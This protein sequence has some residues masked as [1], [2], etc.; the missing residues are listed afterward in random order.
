MFLFEEKSIES[1]KRQEKRQ[2]GRK[3][4]KIGKLNLNPSKT[5]GETQNKKKLKILKNLPVFEGGV[6]CSVTLLDVTSLTDRPGRPG[7]SGLRPF[8][9]ADCEADWARLLEDLE[10]FT[11]SPFD[12]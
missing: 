9:T 10:V 8:L 7:S 12:V 2:N 1:P 3:K 5:Q 6:H 11:A 4:L